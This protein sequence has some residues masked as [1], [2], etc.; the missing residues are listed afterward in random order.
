MHVALPLIPFNCL[1]QYTKVTQG[2]TLA[3]RRR[4]FSRLR[5]FYE[6]EAIP[7]RSITWM[8]VL[9]PALCTTAAF[10]TDKASVDI[11]FSF[12]SHGKVFPA[13]QYDV[14]MDDDR[15]MLTLSSRTNPADRVSSMTV[16]AELSSTDA[17]L[18]IQ[19]DQVGRVHELHAIRL[20]S[21]MTPALDEHW[22]AAKGRTPAQSGQ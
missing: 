17:P 9:T 11:P 1:R 7:M 20:G 13:S 18:S 22:I 4:N 2:Y 19:F 21:Y 16:S 3:P 5:V 6:Q 8:L 15:R 10:A 14:S 12:E